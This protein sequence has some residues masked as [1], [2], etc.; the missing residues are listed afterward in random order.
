METMLPAFHD[1]AVA[2]AMLDRLPQHSNVIT[3]GG[4]KHQLRQR[5][6]SGLL[7]K[8]TT[9]EPAPAET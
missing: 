9:P 7:Q 8:A 4:D 2:K 1:A 3:V 5:R 6:R